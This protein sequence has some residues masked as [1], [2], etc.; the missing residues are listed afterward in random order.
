MTGVGKSNKLLLIFDLNKTLM[1]A[2]KNNRTQYYNSLDML[3]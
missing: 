3:K 1:L 2:A